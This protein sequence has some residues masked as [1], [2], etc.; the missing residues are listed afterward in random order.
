MDVFIKGLVIDHR[1]TCGLEE[2]I[3]GLPFEQWK[4]MTMHDC[5]TVVLNCLD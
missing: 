5:S 4:C 3:L 2:M 1:T